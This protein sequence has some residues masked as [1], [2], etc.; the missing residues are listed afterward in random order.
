[1]TTWNSESKFQFLLFWLSVRSIDNNRVMNVLL[2]FNLLTLERWWQ[3]LVSCSLWQDCLLL[4]PRVPS[5]TEWPN[6]ILHARSSD[7][8]I[9]CFSYFFIIQH[10]YW[11]P[12][13][14]EGCLKTKSH[15][16]KVRYSLT[17]V[18]QTMMMTSRKLACEHIEKNFF[19][20]WK[21]VSLVDIDGSNHN[22]D[23]SEYPR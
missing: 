11:V 4:I 22:D 16:V 15:K 1:M 5:S 20:Y 2:F 14:A 23:L 13:S 19:A 9:V 10:F 12:L 3:G 8:H 7:C 21:W 18:A 6:W 17:S